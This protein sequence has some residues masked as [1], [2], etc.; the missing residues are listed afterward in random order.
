MSTPNGTDGRAQYLAFGLA[1]GEYAIG[2][3]RVR[4]ILQYEEITRVPSTPRSIRGVINLRGSVVPVVDLA[5]KLG[6]PEAPVTRHSCILVIDAAREGG[7]VVT[8]LVVDA[9]SEVVELGRDDVEEPPSFGPGVAVNFLLG[10]GKVGRRFVHL[11]DI[12]WILSADEAALAAAVEAQ[13]AAG[14]GG[15]AASGLSDEVR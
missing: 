3:L 14:D 5:A 1:G 13:R 7:A 15:T 8:G 10:L 6:L 12:D 11:I 4:E 9:V 2:I